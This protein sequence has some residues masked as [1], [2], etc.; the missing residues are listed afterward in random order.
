MTAAGR[1]QGTEPAAGICMAFDHCQGKP[2]REPAD[3]DPG[4]ELSVSVAV[5]RL[6]LESVAVPVSRPEAIPY[7]PQTD[8]IQTTRG[9][10]S[11]G[12]FCSWFPRTRRTTTACSDQW[13]SALAP[14]EP[15]GNTRHR[16]P[17]STDRSTDHPQ[18][19]ASRRGMSTLSCHLAAR[20]SRRQCGIMRC[21]LDGVID[22]PAALGH[23]HSLGSCFDI[24][25]PEHV[26]HVPFHG[27]STEI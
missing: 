5:P 23:N 7:G 14:E 22:E 18:E 26:V 27:A 15:V 12:T 4:N 8:H 1:I 2:A 20:Q 25:F 17:R 19:I 11:T 24:Q 16:S 6:I 3:H 10:S 21:L 9:R 13:V